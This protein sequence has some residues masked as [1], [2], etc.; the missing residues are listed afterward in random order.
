[1]VTFVKAQAASLAA[2]IV[3]FSVFIILT[4]RLNCWYLA[5]SI[6]GTISGGITNFLLGRVW[7]FDATQGKVPKQ[8]FKY[9]LVW[10]GNLLLVS[11]GVFVVTEY[12]QLTP[13]ASKIIVSLIVGFTYNYMLQKK[14]VFK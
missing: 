1:M 7:V 12:A 8:A 2:T 10:A 9:I 14:F 6:T 11:G 13:L 3:D 5:A 4:E